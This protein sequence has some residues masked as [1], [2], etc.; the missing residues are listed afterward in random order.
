MRIRGD[1]ESMGDVEEM[2]ACVRM[3]SPRYPDVSALDARRSSS[4]GTAVTSTSVRHETVVSWLS[5]SNA[6]YPK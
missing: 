3:V 5:A 6:S 4:C 1:A 2:R